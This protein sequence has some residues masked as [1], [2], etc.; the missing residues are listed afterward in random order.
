[1]PSLLKEEKVPK[2]PSNPL[3]PVFYYRLTYSF[4]SSPNSRIMKVVFFF[5][6][7]I[8]FHFSF[9]FFTVFGH[10]PQKQHARAIRRTCLIDRLL[11]PLCWHFAVALGG[12]LVV[13]LQPYCL[14]RLV[15]YSTRCSCKVALCSV[16][17]IRLCYLTVLPS[18]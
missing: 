1:M 2:K 12:S 6:S 10:K 5:S 18:A 14:S 17:R 11:R 3:S 8:A 16:L 7:Y 15:L 13:K 9:Y 4:A